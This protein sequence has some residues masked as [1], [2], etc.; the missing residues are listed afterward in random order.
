MPTFA[1]LGQ[2]TS[3]AIG[4]I[5]AER[6]NEAMEILQ[7]LDGEVRSIHALLG[8]KDLLLLVDF[9][10]IEAAMTGSV[11]LSKATGIAC[12][13][14]PAVSVEEFDRMMDEV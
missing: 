8:D 3:Q 5:S 10:S 11:A 14:Y 13:T 4:G 7:D 1:M 12:T 9:P 6:T 2:Y